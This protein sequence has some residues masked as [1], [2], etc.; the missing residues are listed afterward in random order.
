MFRTAAQIVDERNTRNGKG[1]AI[2]RCSYNLKD[3]IAERVGISNLLY[4]TTYVIYEIT[5]HDG[6]NELHEYQAK[7]LGKEGV[8]VPP[9]FGVTSVEEALS[10]AKKLGGDSGL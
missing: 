5:F 8:A 3:L 9:G 2:C 6:D 4:K 1:D 10:A 7:E